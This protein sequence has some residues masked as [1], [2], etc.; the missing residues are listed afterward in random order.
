MRGAVGH[1]LR[2]RRRRHGVDDARRRPVAAAAGRRRPSGWAPLRRSARRSRRPDGSPPGL[3]GDGDGGGGR[4]AAGLGHLAGR[5]PRGVPGDRPAGSGAR[6]ADLGS[7]APGRPRSAR[8]RGLRPR[9]G[10]GGTRRRAGD[11]RGSRR[12]GGPTPS[13]FRS[14]PTGPTTTAPS[15]TSARSTVSACSASSSRWPATTSPGTATWPRPLVTPI[16]LDESLDSPARVLGAV[17]MG[18]CAVVCVKP[19][20]LGGIGAALD[21]IDWCRSVGVTWWI[22]GMFE[23]GV[24][25][26]ALVALAALAGPTLPGRPRSALDVSDPGR[27]RHR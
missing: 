7:L 11:R 2:P 13:P 21:V 9:Q 22:G 5:P 23:S 15:P 18:A 10:E 14:M 20:R 6:P 24:A 19:S 25:R 17:G 26:R 1:D 8:R 16:C 12:R 27:G 4:L 3:V